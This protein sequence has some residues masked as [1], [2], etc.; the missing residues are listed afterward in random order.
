MAGRTIG[1]VSAVLALWLALSIA[2]SEE[3]KLAVGQRGAW[4]TAVAELGHRAGIFKTHGI[5]L[6][7]LYTQGGAETQQAVLS[8]SVDIGVAAGTLGALGVAAK[9]A[10]LRIIGGEATGVGE[11]Y[12]YVPMASPIRTADDM[13]SRS[14]GYSTNGSSSHTPLL[15]LA[16]ERKV[17]VKLVATGGL[18]ATLTQ[19]MSGQV[20]VGWAVAP[21]GLDQ[22]DRTIRIVA[23]G[24]DVVATRQLTTR[25][26]I[27]HA[28]ILA[29]KIWVDESR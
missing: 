3:L 23:R 16:K 29:Q 20:D 14:V 8:R 24:S 18:A 1:A 21:F 26:L 2:E 25:V 15:Q 9:G 19:V 11:L 6:Q 10:P 17:E 12:W 27:A 13:A 7:I 22:V 5:D 28:E 4:D